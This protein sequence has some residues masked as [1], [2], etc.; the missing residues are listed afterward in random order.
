[1][2]TEN[3]DWIFGYLLFFGVLW[4]LKQSVFPR[5]KCL[6]VNLNDLSQIMFLQ[7]LRA[8][9]QLVVKPEVLITVHMSHVPVL[10]ISFLKDP[11]VQRRLVP[12]H[13]RRFVVQ[14]N[15][16]PAEK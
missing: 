3:R 10:R 4:G 6:V 5:K 16:F 12:Y 9:L 11:L 7:H 8:H 14:G 2:R 1:M 13:L 15:L